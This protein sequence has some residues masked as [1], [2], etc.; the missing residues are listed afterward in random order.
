[1]AKPTKYDACCS[2]CYTSTIAKGVS[3]KDADRA[4]VSHSNMYGHHTFKIE[5]RKG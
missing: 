4:C 1:M 3:S 2:T 5:A